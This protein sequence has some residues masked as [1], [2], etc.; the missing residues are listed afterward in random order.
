M[1]ITPPGQF[2]KDIH[3]SSYS[4]DK[5]GQI[6]ELLFGEYERLNAEKFAELEARVKELEL[7][8]HQRLDVLQ[9][10]LDALAGEVA[11][12]QKAS[13]DELARGLSDLGERVRAKQI[14]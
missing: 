2:K 1:N 4:D 5:M 12:N 9:A 10:R 6:R 8:V 3:N 14:P 13:F 7:S 11:S